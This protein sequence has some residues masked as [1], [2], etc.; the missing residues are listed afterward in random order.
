[1]EKFSNLKPLTIDVCDRKKTACF[2]KQSLDQRATGSATAVSTKT[3]V[4]K[5]LSV[6]SAVLK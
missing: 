5:E 2:A 3:R 1:M 4:T 6:K